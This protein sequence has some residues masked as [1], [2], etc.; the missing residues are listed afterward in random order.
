MVSP[1]ESDNA[2]WRDVLRAVSRCAAAWEP[3]ARILGDVRAID[4]ER[5]CNVA[6][7][8]RPPAPGHCEHGVVEG[9]W[10]QDCYAD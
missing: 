3:E 8:L 7:S 5:A 2:P 9:Y 4:V 6:V 1:C 10:C